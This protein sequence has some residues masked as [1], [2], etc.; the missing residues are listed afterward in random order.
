MQPSRYE[1]NSVVVREAQILC[2]PVVVTNYPTVNSQISDG[3]DGVI[4]PTDNQG[5]AQGIVALLNDKTKQK[6]I[7]Q[8]LQ[9]HDYGNE[10]VIE[11]LYDIA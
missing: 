7:E 6:E 4:V 3:K 5:C 1:G 11:R 9:T 2:K 10:A 8:Y